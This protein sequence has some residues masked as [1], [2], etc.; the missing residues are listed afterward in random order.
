MQKKKLKY[1]NWKA[2][3]QFDFRLWGNGENFFDFSFT[4]MYG[5][6][7]FP[8]QTYIW[9]QVVDVYIDL[10]IIH[11]KISSKNLFPK[12]ERGAFIKILFDKKVGTY[13]FI[14]SSTK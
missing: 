4:K 6:N 1:D 13:Y 3:T 5:S 2:E 11:R 10:E 9:Y 12:R 14:G 7:F 8:Y